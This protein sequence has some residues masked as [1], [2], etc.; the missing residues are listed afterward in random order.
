[1]IIL[2]ILIYITALIFIGG[3]AAAAI[4]LAKAPLHLRWEL[5]PVPHERGKSSYGGSRLEQLPWNDKA[6]SKDRINELMSMSEE[7]LFLNAVRESNSKLWKATYPFHL[8]LYAFFANKGLILITVL[9]G[10]IFG[11]EEC[12]GFIIFMH[13]P[14]FWL[15]VL[16]SMSG[17]IGS[18]V[19][20]IRR[21]NDEA[22][23]KYSTP[24]HYFDII[25]IA[26]I[27]AT[28]FLW[29][30]T[31]QTFANDIISVFTSLILF[32]T[33]PL[34]PD[35]AIAN[36]IFTCIF[37]IYMPFTH[38]SHM[39]TK[40]FSYHKIRWDDES[41]KPGSDKNNK[42]VEQLNKKITWSAG[43][44]APEGNSTWL[45]IAATYNSDELKSKEKN[46]G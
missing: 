32:K 31:S 8:G 11:F 3:M 46:N 26:S 44:I 27:F 34:L 10:I 43:H 40:Y 37:L 12:S 35:I 2:Q 38:L 45:D 30:L 1:M 7:I 25:I 16:G 23:R 5:Y 21:V 18:I 28:I 29:A 36:F 9:I 15:A 19:L 6:E 22:L 24:S 41:Y 17:I 33:L 14:I 39:I 42:I 13:Y 4:R 20:F